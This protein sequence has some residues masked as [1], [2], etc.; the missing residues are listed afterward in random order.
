MDLGQS[1][2]GD[3]CGCGL[4]DLDNGSVVCWVCEEVVRRIPP[5]KGASSMSTITEGR[6]DEF[7]TSGG[8]SYEGAIMEVVAVHE[9]MARDD[10]EDPIR[11]LSKAEAKR[12]L[13][14]AVDLATYALAVIRGDIEANDE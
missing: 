11:G 12:L 8:P 1:G 3:L 5:I 7:F 2:S 10:S 4:L 9:R 13:P 6:V 14:V